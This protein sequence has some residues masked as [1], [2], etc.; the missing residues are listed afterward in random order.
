MMVAG[1]T[2]AGDERQPVGI[3]AGIEYISADASLL[4][5]AHSNG[6]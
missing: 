2:R 1:I 5:P 6:A 4:A 3:Y